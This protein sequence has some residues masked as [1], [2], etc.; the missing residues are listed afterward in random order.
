MPPSQRRRLSDL[1]EFQLIQAIAR[2]FGSSPS[3]SLL[4][5]IGDDA[6]IIQSHP[7]HNWL[8][9]TDL[10]IEGIHFNLR[11]ASFYDIGYR[12]AVAN[13]SDIAAMGGIPKFLLI[14]LA[15]PPH[16]SMLDLHTLYRGL[17][18]PCRPHHVQLIGGDTS[19]SRKDIFLSVTI[20][21]TIEP[22]RALPRSGA[23]VGDHIYATGTLGD[24]SAGLALLQSKKKNSKQTLGHRTSQFL[25][26]RHLRPTP[27]LAMGRLLARYQLANAAIDLSDGL[28]GDLI[29]LCQ[30]SGVGALIEAD[31]IPFSP[32]YRTFHR[33]L[34]HNPLQMALQGGEDYE[35]LFTVPEHKQSELKRLV[36][37]QKIPITRIGAIQPRKLGIRLKLDDNRYRNITEKSYDHFRK[38]KSPIG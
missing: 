12:A 18:S 3:P 23:Q 4:K 9:S 10:L 37:R 6:S 5:G 30:E 2:G 25:M 7:D 13:L 32:Q 29:H 21:G 19:A 24:S 20:M 33:Q 31:T 22:N 38:K 16:Y 28:S 8:V 26:N 27:R 1:S 17:L 34:G 14:A 15:I 11:F 35:L 36:K